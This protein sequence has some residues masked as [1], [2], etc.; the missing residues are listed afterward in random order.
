MEQAIQDWINSLSHERGL[1]ANT[2]QSYERDVRQYMHFLRDSYELSG[3]GDSR[4]L[5]LTAFL[6]QLKQSR[7]TAA[8]IS[9]SLAAIRAL[10]KYLLRERL[11]DH[12]PS[13][14]MEAP[15]I[16]R[17]LPKVISL[18]DVEKLLEAPQTD[19]EAGV[20]DKTMLELLYAS[21][22]RV[23]ELVDLNVDSINLDMSFVRC[24]GS[25]GKERIIPLGGIAVEWLRQYIGGARAALVRQDTLAEPALFISQLGTRMT[26]QGFWKLLKKYAQAAGVD[27][28]ITPHTLRHSFASH[29]LENGADLRAVQ[30][31][32]GHADITTTQVYATVTKKRLKDVYELA[33][34]RAK[35]K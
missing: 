25:G 35:Q 7:K 3:W 32:L 12:D 13:V 33:H 5:H 8:T 14:H 21:G 34:P 1:A 26:R 20:R 16:D 22:I 9:R 6:L 30:E 2:L 17:K 31:M 11:V 28:D 27:A 10:Y 19:T 24:V 4:K 15:R 18:T 29:L 23:S